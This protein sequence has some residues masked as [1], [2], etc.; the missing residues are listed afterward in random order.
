MKDDF[1]PLSEKISKR[2]PGPSLKAELA[3]ISINLPTP[4]RK[5]VFDSY[6]TPE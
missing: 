1:T 3:L 5:S 6:D 2:S 4:I